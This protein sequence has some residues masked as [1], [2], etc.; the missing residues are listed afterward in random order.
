M[1]PLSAP[2]VNSAKEI[3][4][5]QRLRMEFYF[6]FAGQFITKTQPEIYGFARQVSPLIN[7]SMKIAYGHVCHIGDI[8]QV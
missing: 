7:I 2:T 4:T 1:K 5:G 3:A 6:V 8:V